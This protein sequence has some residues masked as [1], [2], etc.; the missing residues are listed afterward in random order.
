MAYTAHIE[1]PLGDVILAS[2]GGAL[3]GC[4]LNGQPGH[5]ALVDADAP[6]R[7]DEP[8][9]ARALGWLERYFAGERPD[10]RELPLAPR[11]TSFQHEV[12][13]LLLDVPYGGLTSYGELADLVVLGRGGGRMAA[14]AIGGAVKRNPISIIVPCHRVLAA[15]GKIGGYS[16]GLDKKL[17]LLAHEGIRL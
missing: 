2:E 7:L 3:V 17:W 12:W 8:V 11:G 4:A 16:G 9:L 1:T 14:Q 13:S 5:R 6:E 10:P 15:H